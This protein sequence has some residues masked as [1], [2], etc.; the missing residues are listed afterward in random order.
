MAKSVQVKFLGANDAVAR[1]VTRDMTA[2]KVYDAK[3]GEL[4]EV[5]PD[6]IQVMYPDEI[7]ITEDDVGEH[8][9]CRLSHGFKII[10]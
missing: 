1:A 3:L 7:W 10:Q 4:G 8:V 9:V 2:G 6:G 5:D